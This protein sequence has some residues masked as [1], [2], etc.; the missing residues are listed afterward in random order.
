MRLLPD[1][2]V[3]KVEPG[4]GFD[5]RITGYNKPSRLPCYVFYICLLLEL[6]N[7]LVTHWTLVARCRWEAP[8]RC[9]N[10]W[11]FQRCRSGRRQPLPFLEFRKVLVPCGDNYKRNH[12]GDILRYIFT[13][14]I[15]PILVESHPRRGEKIIWWKSLCFIVQDAFVLVF[16]CLCYCVCFCDCVCVSLPKML[17]SP[18]REGWWPPSSQKPPA[19]VHPSGEMKI[20]NFVFENLIL[21]AG[22]IS[23]KFSFKEF[24]ANLQNCFT[25]WQLQPLERIWGPVANIYF[26]VPVSQV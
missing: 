26:L 10:M 6:G 11:N 17:N 22:Q 7:Q 14:L 12:S 13:G 4:G 20:T 19:K 5:D 1:S 24:E 23:S 18:V 15:L 8:G 3:N 2:C 25:R 16:V 21:A 9:R